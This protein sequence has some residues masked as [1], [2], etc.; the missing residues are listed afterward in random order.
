M[1][2]R[3]R[4]MAAINIVEVVF[5]PVLDPWL[6]RRAEIDLVASAAVVYNVDRPRISI[7]GGGGTVVIGTIFRGL[8][9][10]VVPPIPHSPEIGGL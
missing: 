7:T 5:E 10:N 2:E 1:K 3:H 8:G 6:R 4:G 9:I